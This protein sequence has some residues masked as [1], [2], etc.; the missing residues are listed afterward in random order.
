MAPM[1]AKQRERRGE[2]GVALALVVIGM[3]AF[4]PLAVVA[5]DIG[6]LALTANEVQTVADVAATAGAQALLKGG[7]ATTARSNAQTVVAQNRVAGSAATIQTGYLLIG[8]YDPQSNTFTNGALPPNAV[9]ATPQATVQNLVAGYF[10]T[11]FLNTTVAKTATAGFRGL[12]KAVATLP[13]AIGD[14]AG[15]FQSPSTCFAS[16]SCLL[17]LTKAPRT[18]SPQNTTAWTGFTG[19]A[20]ST[21]IQKYVPSACGGSLTAPEISVGTSISLTNAVITAVL[22]KVKTCFTAGVKEFRVPVVA[23]SGNFTSSSTVTG[24]ATIVV[25][26]V[27]NSGST[28]LQG[29][30]FHGIYKEVVGTPGGGTFGTGSMRL[31]N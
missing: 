1:T 10:G 22:T 17:T 29:I 25:D 21:N 15:R 12:G 6:R 14:C 16:N 28:S 13:F 27:T 5:V 19:T 24:F 23:C 26:S 4:V 8:Q 20:T 31:F 18:T 3:A 2:R 30:A 9:R 7:T 11:S